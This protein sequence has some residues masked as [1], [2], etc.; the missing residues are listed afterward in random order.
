MWMRE[1]LPSEKSP[2]QDSALPHLDTICS[3]TPQWTPAFAHFAWLLSWHRSPGGQ[4]RSDR[5]SNAS[6]VTLERGFC[7]NLY[8]RTAPRRSANRAAAAAWLARWASASRAACTPG[9]VAP[10]WLVSISP[11]RRN[12]CRLCWRDGGFVQM[13]PVNDLPSDRHL[14]SMSCQVILV[15]AP[16]PYASRA[17]FRYFIVASYLYAHSYQCA[18]TVQTF[19]YYLHWIY[20]LLI[21]KE[22]V[23]LRSRGAV[24]YEFAIIWREMFLLWCTCQFTSDSLTSMTYDAIRSP[25]ESHNH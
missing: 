3:Q 4:V 6:H 2:Q 17:H 1:K 8:P 25:A 10:D 23:L 7:A 16:F 15:R 20:K 13:L 9:D 14:Q 19:I 22:D 24:Y 12:L 18:T 21:T 11:A 5:L